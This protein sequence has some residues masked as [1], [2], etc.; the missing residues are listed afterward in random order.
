MNDF[1]RDRPIKNLAKA[2]EATGD[3]KT[4]S[5]LLLLGQLTTAHGRLRKA[6]LNSGNTLSDMGTKT[7]KDI[8]R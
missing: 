7:I 8:A 4:A 2:L 3:G 5:R 1:I 6:V